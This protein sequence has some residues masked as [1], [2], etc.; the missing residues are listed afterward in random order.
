MKK[1]LLLVFLLIFFSINYIQ[2]NASGEQY[3]EIVVVIDA[4]HG[5]RDGG[6]VSANGYLEKDIALSI[7]NY[8][9]LYLEDVGVNVIMTRTDDELLGSSKRDDLVNRTN[10]INSSN[11]DLFLSIHL[12]AIPDSR[13]RGSQVFYTF[14]NDE[15]KLL[16]E[17]IQE[18]LKLNLNNT[19]RVAK[20]ISN[21]YVMR[22]SN[23][24]GVLVETGFLSNYDEAEL[25]N[26]EDYQMKIAFA[27]YSGVIEYLDELSEMQP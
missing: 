10:I 1:G 13:W 9:K 17:I 27:I 8:L 24:V 14:N 3:E 6:A 18:Q 15:N 20:P 16:A 23:P 26:S 25:L 19:H 11:C 4:G 7:S 21:I 5:G 22:E 2:Y 12:N